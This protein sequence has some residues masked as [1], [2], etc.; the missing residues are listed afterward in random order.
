MCLAYLKEN[1]T[2]MHGIEEGKRAAMADRGNSRSRGREHSSGR[3]DN[4]E[5]DGGSGRY[6][7][8]DRNRASV[9]RRNAY[10]NP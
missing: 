9:G 4:R 1:R 7:N 6:D 5:K 8:R 2:R 10:Y 3:Y